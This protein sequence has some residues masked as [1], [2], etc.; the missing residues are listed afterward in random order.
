M[1]TIIGILTFISIASLVLFFFFRE[2]RF[3]KK[4][5]AETMAPELWDEIAKEREE[6]MERSKKFREALENARKKT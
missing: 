2:R 5:T 3:E 4:T 6:G 1:W